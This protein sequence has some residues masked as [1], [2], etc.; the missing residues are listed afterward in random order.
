MMKPHQLGAT[1]TAALVSILS[2][3]ISFNAASADSE[4]RSSPTDHAPID[5][6]AAA[7]V[8]NR[9]IDNAAVNSVTLRKLRRLKNNIAQTLRQPMI[10]CPRH[11]N[12]RTMPAGSWRKR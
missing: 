5:S 4:G 8:V 9:I 2:L 12:A 6:D 10:G 11:V 3:T 1:R 7:M